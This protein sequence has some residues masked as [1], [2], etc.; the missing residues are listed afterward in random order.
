MLGL[1]EKQPELLEQ[2]ISEIKAHGMPRDGVYHMVTPGGSQ[3]LCAPA[4][5]AF[6]RG[7]GSP[8]LLAKPERTGEQDSHT[9]ELLK[10][11]LMDPL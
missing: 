5:S 6:H 7:P 8:A 3:L 9:E 1:R 11:M 2:N 10:S 4:F